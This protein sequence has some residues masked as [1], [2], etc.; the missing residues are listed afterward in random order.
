MGEEWPGKTGG[1]PGG[2]A[3][4]SRIAGYV[5][6]EEI[7][8]GGMAVVFRARDERLDRLVALKLLTPGL[9]VTRRTSPGGAGPGPVAVQ[10]ERFARHLAGQADALG[11]D[12]PT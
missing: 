6:E 7:G 11:A 2:P 3:A 10:M 9:A 1:G 5:L 8:A 4:G 12:A